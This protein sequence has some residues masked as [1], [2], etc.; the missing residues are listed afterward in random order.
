MNNKKGTGKN[1]FKTKQE[2]FEEEKELFS[3]YRKE[4]KKNETKRNWK[5]YLLRWEKE[6]SIIGIAKKVAL[7]PTRVRQL[8]KA[9]PYLIEKRIFFSRHEKLFK[10]KLSERDYK[11]CQ[12]RWKE[13]KNSEEIGK[14][15]KLATQYVY[16]LLSRCFNLIKNTIN[17]QKNDEKE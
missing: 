15:L 7:S 17:S 2:L 13:H 9:F 8:L 1:L 10:Q 14:E 5:V 12:M 16:I 4:I 3:C 11:M 6:L